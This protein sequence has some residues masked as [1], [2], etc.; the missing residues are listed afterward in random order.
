MRTR[1]VV[2]SVIVLVLLGA[3][4]HRAYRA[5]ANT[6]ATRD[7]S[8]PPGASL[9]E[10]TH[11][12]IVST[13][14]PE[15]ARDV[16]AAVES[17]YVAYTGFFATP[18]APAP[19]RKLRLVLY[20]DRAEFKAH[21]RYQPWAEAFYIPD[22]CHAYYAAGDANPYHWMVH[23]ATHQLNHE[24]ARLKPAKWVNEG[25]ASYFG[26]S[27]IV[28]GEL[29]PG[30]IDPGTYPIWWLS[31]TPLGDDVQRDIDEGRFIPLAALINNTGPDI[32]RHVNLY[33]VEYWS[34]S[35]FLFHYQ[36]GRYADGY[37]ALIRKGGSL[38]DFERLVGPVPVVQ[39]QWHAYL[40]QRIQA[41]AAA[42]D[43]R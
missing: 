25:L 6:T 4:G 16:A 10:T 38:A 31:R 43:E 9:L 27:R 21:N 7:P 37:R 41:A 20:R 36:Q 1:N 12:T 17:L 32:G 23:E 34:L 29:H 15:Q 2:A 28:D 3:L 42:G 33:Y 14:A 13:A 22:S 39:A 19:T 18:Q 11:Y 35:H 30:T 26:A 24:V 40:L 5:S 8:T